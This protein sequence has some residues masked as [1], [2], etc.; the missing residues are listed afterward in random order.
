MVIAHNHGTCFASTN[1]VLLLAQHHARS[2]SNLNQP[3]H[4]RFFY[5]AAHERFNQAT[6]I[7][8]D[9]SHSDHLYTT[10]SERNACESSSYDDAIA[11]RMR[12]RRDRQR[13]LSGTGWSHR[14]SRMESGSRLLSQWLFCPLRPA[15]IR[16]TG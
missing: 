4:T 10:T 13:S 12:Q 7:P 6:I 3:N 8:A 11:D 1:R 9:Q 5:A 2:R 15:I 16:S 14:V